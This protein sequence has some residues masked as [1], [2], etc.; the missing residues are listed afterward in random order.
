[1]A[2]TRSI[3][4][5]ALEEHMKKQDLQILE[6][7]EWRKQVEEKINNWGSHL[8]A[9]VDQQNNQFQKLSS[10]LNDLLQMM[11]E[12]KSDFKREPTNSSK[13][14]FSSSSADSSKPGKV[15]HVIRN[16]IPG[17]KGGSHG[18]FKRLSPQEIQY[19]RNNNLCWKCA[20]K[21]NPGHVC[22]MKQINFITME[23]DEEA[24]DLN[25]I[26][27]EPN[28]AGTIVELSGD[29]I[30]N[31]TQVEECW[32][33]EEEDRK[34]ILITGYI[35]GVRIRILIDTGATRSF[36]D[37]KL[38]FKLRL[39]TKRIRPFVVTVADGYKLRNDQA[40]PETTWSIQQRG[41]R[42]LLQGQAYESYWRIE[43]VMQNMERNKR[44]REQWE[45]EQQMRRQAD[46]RRRR[47]IQQGN[48]ADAGSRPCC[49]SNADAASSRRGLECCQSVRYDFALLLMNVEK[50]SFGFAQ[51]T[52]LTALGHAVVY[53]QK[54]F[55]PP[56]NVDS[57]LEEAAKV[58][59]EIYAIVRVYGKRVS[60]LLDGGVWNL[61]KTIKFSPGVPSGL[62]RAKPIK[63]GERAQIHCLENGWV[64]IYCRNAEPYTRRFPDVV[65]TISRVKKHS[66]TSFVL[67]CELVAYD[68]EKKKIL[69]GQNFFYASV[70]SSSE[71]LIIKTLNRDATYEPSK[72]SNNWLK[73]KIDYME[74]IG[75]TLDLVPIGALHG[76]GKWAGFYVTFLLACYDT[77]REEFQSICNIGAGITD[78]ML[79]E[80]SLSLKSKVIP[81]PRSH[82]RYAKD[83]LPD[84][85]FEPTEVW[86][87]KGDDLIISDSHRAATATSIVNHDEGISLLY[88]WLLRV[89]EDKAPRDA[90]S[91]QIVADM[92]ITYGS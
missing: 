4:T 85:W 75:H 26:Q 73:L 51:R 91:A 15:P 16:T 62:M 55:P 76:E 47:Y 31:I 7:G 10:Q 48:E 33:L 5:Q 23:E 28:D 13:I 29:Q 19:R 50:F 80:R 45:W 22:K 30:Q 77:V 83:W 69:P 61:P 37:S 11:N 40:C 43:E 42:F 46:N 8:D 79:K 63:D 87:V 74:S 27:E 89:R 54:Q 21:W 60:A 53:A 86:E 38:V 72:R 68:R 84:V 49:K 90:T 58:V 1:M 25:W 57:P 39:N 14:P 41:E 17:Q 78:A 18:A 44:R 71:G 12:P 65:E 24:G 67:D 6:I 36:I 64:E 20:E 82:S 59:K 56:P 9:K 52:L 92:Y 2:E 70:D 34:I 88:P 32:S 35:H 81:K 66:A 3:T